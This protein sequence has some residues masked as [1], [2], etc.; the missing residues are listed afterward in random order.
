MSSE[1]E[2]LHS[3][4]IPRLL[5]VDDDPAVRRLV[6]TVAK[7]S[8]FIAEEAEDGRLALEV[9]EKLRPDVV[10]LDVM[11]P[12][13]NGF[14]TCVALRNLSSGSHIPIIFMTGLED[15][16][17][18]DRAYELGATEFIIKPINYAI[19]KHRLRYIMR[20]KQLA[21][22]LRASEQRLRNAQRVAKLGQ[23]EWDAQS[24]TMRTFDV[25]GALFKAGWNTIC[26]KDYLARISPDHQEAFQS[27]FS[28][29]AKSTSSLEYGLMLADGSERIVHQL[30]ESSIR[31]EDNVLKIFG[32]VRDV[33]D[34]MYAD[35]QIR[36]LTNYDSITGLPNRRFLTMY[37]DRILENAKRY[38]RTV[39]VVVLEFDH[40]K[41]VEDTLGH[42]V[43]DHLLRKIADRLRECVRGGDCI[44]RGGAK[45]LDS[46][47]RVGGHRF[48]IV[49]SE[50]RKIEDA[51]AVVERTKEN[52]AR[53]F[54]VQRNEINLTASVG[55]SAF[56]ADGDNSES[57]LKH[58]D[59]AVTAAKEAGRNRYEFYTSAINSRLRRRQSV[60][61]RLRRA[62]R[63]NELSVHYQPKLNLINDEII[64]MEA[65]LRWTD[66]ELGTVKPAEI[67]P[68]AED[69]GLI[70]DLNEW[71]LRAVCLQNHAWQNTSMP[72]LVVSL[73]IAP[74]YLDTNNF[75]KQVTEVL[76]DTK[77]DPSLLELELSE[78]ALTERH[79][80][81]IQSVTDLRDI[82]VQITLDDFG[83]GSSSL[84]HL[85]RFPITGLKIDESFIQGIKK[86]SS[87]TLIV[88]AILALAKG[89]DLKAV[90][91]GVE[92]PRQLIYLK[93]KL[94][95]EVQGN[96]I[97]PPL[98]ADEFAKWIDARAGTG[99]NAA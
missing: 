18:V 6:H 51:A 70:V 61:T 19:L 93:S 25:N 48:V 73:N 63:R 34:R 99:D 66:S 94:C 20:A 88:R 91:Q 89:M 57:L 78:N 54:M 30:T 75:A 60:E 85:K 46:I 31:E 26:F 5:I 95:D 49:L 32:T 56:P 81:T 9:F 42:E 33:T 22:E 2:N 62:L 92:K 69:S 43:R 8:G 67:L 16:P 76:N 90:A 72:A 65:L 24:N 29:T 53:P 15:I 14:D 11:M 35:Q 37:L 52:L 23:W 98:S 4:R 41:R 38:R 28:D 97:N 12:R 58:A 82:G 39:A 50:I 13:M 83:T 45:N 40:F 3:E 79:E 68:I 80:N 64:G 87:D 1:S 36:I 27:I 55:I 84:K 7:Q 44:S 74:S 96:L 86:T 77:L 47:A 17:S 59:L 10:L 71:M 21:D